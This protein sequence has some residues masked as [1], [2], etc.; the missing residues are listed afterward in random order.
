VW[1]IEAEGEK[2]VSVR[3][4][5]QFSHARREVEVACTYKE[6]IGVRG[7]E[8]EACARRGPQPVEELLWRTLLVCMSRLFVGG[9]A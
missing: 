5:P 8:S 9:V 4:V 3:N 2:D 7:I 6:W 1:S